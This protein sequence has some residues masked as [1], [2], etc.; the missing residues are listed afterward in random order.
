MTALITLA[1]ILIALCV[2][3]LLGALCSWVEK[4]APVIDLRFYS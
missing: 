1:Y 4:G 3:L 2:W